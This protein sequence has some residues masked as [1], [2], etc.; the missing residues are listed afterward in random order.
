MKDYIKT[1]TFIFF[2]EILYEKRYILFKFN[3]LMLFIFFKCRGQ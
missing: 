2:K 3:L 1:A